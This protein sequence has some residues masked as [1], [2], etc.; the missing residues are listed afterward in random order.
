TPELHWIVIN[1]IGTAQHFGGEFSGV[2]GGADRLQYCSATCFIITMQNMLPERNIGSSQR[3]ERQRLMHR[4]LDVDRQSPGVLRRQIRGGGGLACR[5]WIGPLFLL[6][7]GELCGLEGD[8]FGR[9]SAR[10]L[11]FGV[12]ADGDAYPSC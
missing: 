4:G 3:R 11:P 5:P 10:C 7:W 1:G 12:C 6:C 9:A 2:A 8:I